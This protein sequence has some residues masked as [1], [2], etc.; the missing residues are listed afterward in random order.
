MALDYKVLAQKQGTS[1]VAT[2]TTI[3]NPGSGKQWLVS[4]IAICNQ[5]S[6]SMTYRLAVAQ[7]AN[8][9]NPVVSEFIVFGATVPGN[10]T[11]TLTLGVTLENGFSLVSSSSS[12]TSSFSAFGTEI[13]P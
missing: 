4:T 13:T 5:G 6:S 10:D 12:N 9:A 7:N 1:S 2:Y 8:V 11:V 3:G